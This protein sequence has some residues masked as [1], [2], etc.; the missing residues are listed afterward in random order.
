MSTFFLH[1]NPRKLIIVDN[2]VIVKALEIKGLKD[3][4]NCPTLLTKVFKSFDGRDTLNLASLDMKNIENEFLF[5]FLNT[6]IPAKTSSPL[7]TV[8]SSPKQA[9]STKL[10]MTQL[11]PASLPIYKGRKVSPI[12]AQWITNRITSE[13]AL[14]TVLTHIDTTLKIDLEREH[15]FSKPVSHTKNKLYKNLAQMTFNPA[16]ASSL[17]KP[18][19]DIILLLHQCADNGATLV[20]ASNWNSQHFNQLYKNASF[21]SSYK[22]L[23]GTQERTRRII[24]SSKL[25]S[26]PIK[27]LYEDIITEYK[28]ANPKD[29]IAIEVEKSY[30]TVAKQCGMNALVATDDIS[31]LKNQLEKLGALPLGEN[32]P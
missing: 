12:L 24:L 3:L 11:G 32:K 5:T 14:K 10:D 7:V 13:T 27:S 1:G 21:N 6:V 15:Y 23:F 17:F 19:K 18:N 31:E 30:V 28:V 4:Q 29:C 2:A 22:K 20:L 8:S 25:K 9:V 16:H 26:N